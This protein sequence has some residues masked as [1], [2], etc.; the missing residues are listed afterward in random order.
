MPKAGKRDE[1]VVAAMRV[2]ARD[3]T[4]GLTAASLARE[5]GVSKANVFHH[6]ETLNAVVLVAFEAFLVGMDGMRPQAGMPL[7][8][9]LLALGNETASQM[10]GDPA[11]AGAY[12]AFA[13]RAQADPD[14]RRRLAQL[15]TTVE[16]HFEAG[17][18]LLAPA[19]FTPAE[20]RR[21]ASLI[22]ITGDGLALHRQLF[23][24]RRDSQL[25]A[26]RAFVDGIAPEES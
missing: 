16:A 1:I 4:A 17:L 15:A 19:R 5:A 25:A 10:D 6:F 2:L 23:P 26:W 21:L 24:D 13:A 3:G 7:R 22:L 9:W 14:L 11:L 20:R 18:D 8:D 12:F